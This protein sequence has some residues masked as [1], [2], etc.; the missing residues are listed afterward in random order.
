[1]WVAV[2]NAFQQL[3]HIWQLPYRFVARSLQRRRQH[4]PVDV[5]E[6]VG[7]VHCLKARQIFQHGIHRS[8]N[9]IQ[10][11][12]VAPIDL[13]APDGLL[14]R[15]CGVTRSFQQNLDHLFRKALVSPASPHNLH[16]ISRRGSGCASPSGDVS[17]F[18]DGLRALVTSTASS[19][20]SGNHGALGKYGLTTTIVACFL[21]T[22]ARLFGR[23][24]KEGKAYASPLVRLPPGVGFLQSALVPWFLILGRLSRWDGQVNT[25]HELQYH[26]SHTKKKLSRPRKIKILNGCL[27]H[28]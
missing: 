25:L 15:S 17:R 6:A 3:L 21:R 12:F 7:E 22:L 19:S 16:A 18:L 14:G 5:D 20:N 8:W 28:C 9:G 11:P 26:N 10:I 2:K 23:R 27:P 24:P 1:M 4:R 13:I